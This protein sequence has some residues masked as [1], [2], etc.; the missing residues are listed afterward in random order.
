MGYSFNLEVKMTISK[1][2]LLITVLNIPIT[3]NIFAYDPNSIQAELEIIKNYSSSLHSQNPP[4]K[5][6]AK[7]ARWLD[8]KLANENID[9]IY[10]NPCLYNIA[11]E[12]MIAIANVIQSYPQAKEDILKALI[13]DEK[14]EQTTFDARRIYAG[15]T[16]ENDQ[17]IFINA[18]GY[19]DITPRWLKNELIAHITRP[20]KKDGGF[21]WVED[22]FMSSRLLSLSKSQKN[23]NNA[24]K[25]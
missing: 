23:N 18:L 5:Q 12:E 4:T 21:D 11:E 2:L 17:G 14:A 20:M 8:K 10:E 24:L 3:F 22:K 15:Y 6:S 1:K 13:M 16:G 25:Q 19:E 7:I 9:W